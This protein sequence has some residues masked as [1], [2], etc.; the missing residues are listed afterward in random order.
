MGASDGLFWSNGRRICSLKAWKTSGSRK[1]EVT[2]IR[3]SW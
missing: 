1:N 3:Q 2:E